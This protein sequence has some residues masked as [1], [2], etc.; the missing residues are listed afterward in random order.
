MLHGENQTR[1][2]PFAAGRKNG[3][4]KPVLFAIATGKKAGKGKKVGIG[5][6]QEPYG[7]M[8][9]N[10]GV[11]LAI[12]AMMVM[13]GEISQKGILAPEDCIDPVDFFKKLAPLSGANGIDDILV[14][15]F[16]DL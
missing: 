11:P 12:A 16:E 3:V 15:H 7:G 10:T 9:G 14:R 5:L 2:A 8:S 4:Y 1:D 6:I 13:N